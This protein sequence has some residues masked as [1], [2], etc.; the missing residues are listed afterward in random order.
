MTIDTLIPP[1]AQL[2]NQHVTRDEWDDPEDTGRRGSYV[3]VVYGYRR[4][5]PIA[6]MHRRSERDVSASMLRSAERLRDD[7]EI[8]EGTNRNKGSGGDVGPT[9]AMLD[10]M[11]RVRAAERAVGLECWPMVRSVVLWGWTLER[12]AAAA[13][14][15]RTAAMGKVRGVLLDGLRRLDGYYNPVVGRG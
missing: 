12:C 6:T 10:A 15:G 13:G 5:C 3:R 9:I 14:G 1:A 2:R 7:R 8:A 11:A 4:V